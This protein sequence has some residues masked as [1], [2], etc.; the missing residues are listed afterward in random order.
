MGC[1]ETEKRLR[2]VHDL[3]QRVGS[4]TDSII[5]GGSMGFGQHY[6]ITKDSDIDLPILVRPDQVD[7]LVKRLAFKKTPSPSVLN[8]F[9]QS[10]IDCFWHT[11]YKDGVQLDCFVYNPAAHVNFVTHEQSLRIYKTEQPRETTTAFN[12]AGDELSVPRQ[13]MPFLDGFVYEQPVFAGDKYYMPGIRA[14]FFTSKFL[15]QRNQRLDD[16]RKRVWR[17]TMIK[18][19]EEHGPDVNLERTNVLNT[20]YTYQKQRDRLPPEL[21]RTLE[22]RTHEELRNYYTYLKRPVP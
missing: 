15:V 13:S 3:V 21:I 12:F 8:A 18:L 2:I 20:N 17:C 19:V 7:S 22:W 14:D 1:P 10:E 4:D 5:L 6:S 9:A 16:L 11:D